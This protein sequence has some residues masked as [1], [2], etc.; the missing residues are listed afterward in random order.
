MLFVCTIVDKQNASANIQLSEVK[1]TR[2]QLTQTYVIGQFIQP[3]TEL[4][5][6][7]TFIR[8]TIGL[9]TE[10]YLESFLIFY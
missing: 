6:A 7:R 5:I 8:D 3:G 4:R 2:V 10:Q 9:Y 1:S